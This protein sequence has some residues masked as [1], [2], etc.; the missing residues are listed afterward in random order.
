MAHPNNVNVGRWWT[1]PFLTARADT[2]ALHV[3]HGAITS[4]NANAL[5]SFQDAIVLLLTAPI[6]SMLDARSGL[7]SVQ[8]HQLVQAMVTPGAMQSL[9]PW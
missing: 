6:A 1:T 8:E 2:G 3:V 7:S 9:K 5:S 4:D